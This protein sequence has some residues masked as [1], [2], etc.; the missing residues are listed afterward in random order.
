MAFCFVCYA[1][2]FPLYALAIR[3]EAGRIAILV[4]AQTLFGV[5]EAFRT[6]THKAIMLDWVDQT[7]DAPGATRVIGTTRFWSKLAAG[8]SAILGG[9]LL[10]QTGTFLWLFILATVPA[11]C[12]VVLALS[13]PA[14]LDGEYTRQ[15]GTPPLPWKTR[16]LNLRGLPGMTTLALFS[17]VFESHIKV[18][19]HYIQPLLN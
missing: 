7:P 13:Y 16:L 10:W 5:G 4:V 1:L 8:V 17:I 14:W 18:A 19:Q 11:L 15:R 12:G 2:A 9:I 6:G 3:M